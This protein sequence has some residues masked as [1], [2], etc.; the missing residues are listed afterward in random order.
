MSTMRKTLRKPLR[1][2]LLAAVT[3]VP[4]LAL[5]QAAPEPAAPEAPKKSAISQDVGDTA[6]AIKNYSAAQKEE[7]EKKAKA[8]LDDVDARIGELEARVSKNWSSMN[9]AARDHAH[10]TLQ[11]LRK[12]RNEVAEWYGAVKHSSAEAWD[13]VKRGF[14]KSYRDLAESVSKARKEF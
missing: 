8:T 11:A 2:F 9:Q 13:E 6:D 4:A 3:F 7:A 14:S 5:S 10:A 12:K 1:A